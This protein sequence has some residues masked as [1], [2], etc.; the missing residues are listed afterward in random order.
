MDNFFKPT[1]GKIIIFAIFLIINIALYLYTPKCFGSYCPFDG[2]IALLLEIGLLNAF[3][4]IGALGILQNYM[5][6]FNIIGL[7]IWYLISCALVFAYL[8]IKRK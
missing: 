7:I 2:F 3:D 5:I 8:K 4:Q 6:L 1:K